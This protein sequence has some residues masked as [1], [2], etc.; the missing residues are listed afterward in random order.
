M[1]KSV[2]IVGAGSGLS[3]SLARLCV[4]EKM[5]VILATRNID[6]IKEYYGKNPEKVSAYMRSIL[7]HEN[8]HAIEAGGRAGMIAPDMKTIKYLEGKAFSP[9]GKDFEKAKNSWLNLKTD[10]DA[11]YDKK[12]IIYILAVCSK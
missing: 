4:S 3:A 11:V 5:K 12:I 2:L 6:K 9:K 1:N 8:L 7:G 10:E